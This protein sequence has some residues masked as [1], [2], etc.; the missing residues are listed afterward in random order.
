MHKRKDKLFWDTSWKI[1]LLSTLNLVWKILLWVEHCLSEQVPVI[2][3]TI[4]KNFTRYLER[5]RC[6]WA[7]EYEFVFE[8]ITV[9]PS[10]EKQGVRN[11]S[12]QFYLL[13]SS[14]VGSILWGLQR[15]DE[16]HP[17]YEWCIIGKPKRFAFHWYLI[18]IIGACPRVLVINQRHRRFFVYFSCVPRA[19]TCV[20]RP[21]S[22]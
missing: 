18:R 9:S 7:Q 3:A 13:F 14:N 12:W 20:A 19:H 17:E 1:I 16:M 10:L 15:N 21:N 5:F 4:T 11:Q 6:S 2:F 22:Y 8:F